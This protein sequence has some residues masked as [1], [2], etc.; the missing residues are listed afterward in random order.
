MRVAIAAGK[1]HGVISTLTPTG[2]CATM[3]R[4][5]PAGAVVSAPELRTASS[6]NQRKNS[7]AYLASARESG[8]ALPFSSVISRASGSAWAII[9]SKPRRRISARSRGGRAAQP[10]S[11]WCAAAT[12]SR[13]SSTLAAAI[14]VIGCSV[15]GSSTGS[16]PARPEVQSPPISRPVGGLMPATEA[17]S[18]VTDSSTRPAASL[19]RRA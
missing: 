5:A 14:S 11:A 18:N 15:A 10:G 17:R 16:V 6:A 1:F 7:A 13:P 9:A 2:W 12:A 19:L 4:L 8:S 3:I